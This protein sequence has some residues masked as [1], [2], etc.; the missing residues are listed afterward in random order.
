MTEKEAIDYW[1]KNATEDLITSESLYKE[2][3][4]WLKEKT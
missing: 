4:L 1:L 2:I 3:Y